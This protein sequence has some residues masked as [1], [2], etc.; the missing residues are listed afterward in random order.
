M[1]YVSTRAIATA[2]DPL[3]PRQRLVLAKLASAMPRREE[4]VPSI[5]SRLGVGKGSFAL[6]GYAPRLR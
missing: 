6:Y 4:P 2:L 3:D 5:T 1:S